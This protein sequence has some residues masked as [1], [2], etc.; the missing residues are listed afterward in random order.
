MAGPFLDLSDI[1]DTKKDK[2]YFL[3]GYKS[4]TKYSR[5]VHEIITD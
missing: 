4:F 3:T 1:E 5:S 2:L